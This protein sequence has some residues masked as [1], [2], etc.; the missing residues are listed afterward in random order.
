MNLS[1]EAWNLKARAIFHVLLEQKVGRAEEEKYT[2]LPLMVAILMV[3]RPRG[4]RSRVELL[5]QVR[6]GE[7]MIGLEDFCVRSGEY[8]YRAPHL[9]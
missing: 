6:R 8:C 7:E 5:P 1:L 9:E 2:F 3:G 4:K